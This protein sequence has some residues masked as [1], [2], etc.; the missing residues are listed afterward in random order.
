MSLPGTDVEVVTAVG[1]AI[2]VIQ[3]EACEAHLDHHKAIGC[4]QFIGVDLVQGG[5]RIPDLLTG[6]TCEFLV[7][8]DKATPVDVRDD[9]G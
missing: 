7:E 1:D 2:R 3:V 8:G 5:I 4:T 9:G 6:Q